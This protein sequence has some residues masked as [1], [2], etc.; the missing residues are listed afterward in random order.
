MQPSQYN[1]LIPQ[2]TNWALT[3]ELTEGSGFRTEGANAGATQIPLTSPLPTALSNGDKVNFGGAIATL[4]AAA[5]LGSKSLTVSALPFD[6]KRVQG[7][8]VLNVT[9]YTALA[10]IY[11]DFDESA[12]ATLTVDLTTGPSDGRPILKLTKTETSALAATLDPGL[13]LTE[14]EVQSVKE[15]G[16]HYLWQFDLTDTQPNTLRLLEGFVLVSQQGA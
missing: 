3:L 9:G 10:R 1:L 4:T 14:A 16:S 7:Y 11:S 8:K 15:Q 5:A 6:L 2:G 12:I 13:F